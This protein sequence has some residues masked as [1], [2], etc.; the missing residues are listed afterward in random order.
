MPGGIGMVPLAGEPLAGAGVNF[1]VWPELIDSAVVQ[2]PVI[3]TAADLEPFEGCA[4][5]II[6]CDRWAL[7]LPRET[8]TQVMKKR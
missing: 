8:R 6:P 4:D 1:P 7:V 2:V 3:V 5:V